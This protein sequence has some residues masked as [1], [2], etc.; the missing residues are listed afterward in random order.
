[1]CR[2]LSGPNVGSAA[3]PTRELFPGATRPRKSTKKEGR[4]EKQ[5]EILL[6]YHLRELKLDYRREF[7]F[8]EQRRWAFDFCVPEHMLALEIEGGIH[9]YSTMQKGQLIRREQGGH[10]TGA[11]YQDDLY[12][13][14]DATIRGW[15]L[16]RFSVSDVMTGLAKDTV[17]R[18][19][20][21][22]KTG[23]RLGNDL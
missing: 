3:V 10:T 1:M 16:L 2:F 22:K 4:E 23:F 15:T 18:Y 17:R 21:A 5:H 20:H 11:G 14:N 19:L 12:K 9:G 13:Y 7:R 8:N 6:G